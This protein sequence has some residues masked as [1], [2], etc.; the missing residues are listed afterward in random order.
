VTDLVVAGGTVV[1]A[2]RAF[3]ADVAITD[4]R[5]EAVAQGLAGLSPDVQVIDAIGL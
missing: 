1:T 2:A 4:G 5:I 3:T